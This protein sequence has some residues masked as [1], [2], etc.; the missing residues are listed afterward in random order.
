MK[1]ITGETKLFGILADPIHHVKTPQRMNEY[2]ARAS[3][4]G[5]LV[6]FHARSDNL[7]SVVNGLKQ[8]ENLVGLIVTVPHKTAI[9]GLCDGASDVAKKIGAANI[10]RREANGRLTAHML[11]GEGF[12]RGLQSCGHEVKGKTAYMA[13]AGG[14]ANAIAFALVQYGVSSLTIANRTTAK[15]QDLMQRVLD[16]YPQARIN[17][18]THNPSDHDIVVNATSLG[19]NEGDALPMDTSALTPDQL[20]CEIIMQP[21]DTALLIAAQER[22]CRVHYGA[23]MLASQIELMAEFLGVTAAR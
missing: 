23:P 7:A 11:D 16:L 17:I 22:G 13:G 2:F 3:Y 20:V 1:E 4:D 19:L 12:V 15:A 9:L 10:V 18:G 8:L 6:P 21:K 5:V 14:A